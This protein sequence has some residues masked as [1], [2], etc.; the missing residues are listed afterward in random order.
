M[1]SPAQ[2]AKTSGVGV[3]GKQLQPAETLAPSDHVAAM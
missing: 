2:L 3:T 1:Q